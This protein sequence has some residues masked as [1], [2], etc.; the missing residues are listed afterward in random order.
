MLAAVGASAFIVAIILVLVASYYIKVHDYMLIV[1]ITLAT[2]C[3]MVIGHRTG[4]TTGKWIGFE[5]STMFVFWT[6]IK[7]HRQQWRNPVLWMS[8]TVLLIV[9]L[10]VVWLVLWRLEQVKPNLMFVIVWLEMIPIWMAL[11]WAL[12]H[13]VKRKHVRRVRSPKAAD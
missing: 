2:G 4:D 12:T 6:V 11:E 1:V 9:H 3:W 10:A 13:F 8:M 7:Q 5:F